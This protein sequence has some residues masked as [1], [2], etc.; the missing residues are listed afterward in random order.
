M[1]DN[2]Y[3]DLFQN[4]MHLPECSEVGGNLMENSAVHEP[5]IIKQ[6]LLLQIMQA[7]PSAPLSPNCDFE[8]WQQW[9][10]RTGGYE[11]VEDRWGSE[12]IA[13]N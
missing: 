1:Y 2:V 6:A 3:Q 7:N 11:K 8:Y 13:E 5:P 4:R 10:P 12:N 9:P